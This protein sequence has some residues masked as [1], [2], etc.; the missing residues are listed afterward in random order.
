MHTDLR[1][2]LNGEWLRPTKLDQKSEKRWVIGKDITPDTSELGD[3]NLKRSLQKDEAPIHRYG[4][5]HPVLGRIT[6]FAE[7]YD[8]T[9]TEHIYRSHGFFV[10]V[11]ERLIN[12][13]DS[14]FGISANSLRH[15]T[16]SRFRMIVHIDDLD[17][18]L[19]SSRESVRDTQ[20]KINAQT[21]LT[22]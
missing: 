11:R 1:L 14:H 5:I 7:I 22:A 20:M 2:F 15:G 19:R 18:E 8:R 4:L 13:D 6:G 12:P 9:L 3:M 21:F 16:F 10:Y 17:K